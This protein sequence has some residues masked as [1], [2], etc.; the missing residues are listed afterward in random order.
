[1]LPPDRLL[2]VLAFDNLSSDPEMDYFSDGVSEE[3]LETVART[4]DLKVIGRSSSFQ[5]RGK[6][7]AAQNVAA[8]LRASHLLDGSVRRSGQRVRITA[9]LVECAHQTTLWSG[10]FDRDLSDVFALQD[11]IAVEVAKALQ[12]VFA[13][14][15]SARKVDPEAYDLYL[16]ARALAGAPPNAATCVRLLEEA[17]SR[18]PHFAAA[19][20]S[21]AMARAIEA[22]W[23]AAPEM[24]AAERDRA[25][26]AAERAIALDGAAGLPLVALSLLEPPGC[27]AAREALLDRAMAASPSDPEILKQASDF[28]ASVGRLQEGYRLIARA[29]EIDPLNQVLVNGLG[30]TLANLGRLDECYRI[31]EAARARWPDFDWLVISPLLIAANLG[32]WRTAEPL[33]EMARADS[34]QFRLALSMVALL[35]APHAAMRQRMIETCERQLSAAGTVELR[36]IS[37]M[38]AHGLKDEAFQALARSSF[39]YRQEQQPERVFLISIIFGVTNAAMRHDPRFVELCG[40]LGLCDYWVASDKWPD[41]V[42]EV[43]SDYD[44]K[45]L[46]REFVAKRGEGAKYERTASS[47]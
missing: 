25:I 14:A 18:S 34:G 12:L 19:W 9:S 29:S 3:I 38:Y 4:S 28:A 46:A 13:P 20:A 42:D 39:D 33:I 35:K 32:D 45:A 47:D 27:F 15:A 23:N 37:F 5:F 43:S 44:L 16:R 40:R 26:V 10:R 21:L 36:I 1:M 22:R 6:D 24:F 41:C 2:A 31:F 17:V 30:V 11:E 7:K 8:Q